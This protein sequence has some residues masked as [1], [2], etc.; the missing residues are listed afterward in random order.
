MIE[1]M[2]GLLVEFA[3]SETP[4]AGEQPLTYDLYKMS[5]IG[6]IFLQAVP[7]MVQ[8]IKSA[9]EPVLEMIGIDNQSKHTF[10]GISFHIYLSL[11]FKN[12][13]GRNQGRGFSN[14]R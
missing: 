12:Y 6:E 2:M 7:K 11:S 13:H 10:T 8:T 3:K 14:Y 1:E 5:L 9:I 4:P